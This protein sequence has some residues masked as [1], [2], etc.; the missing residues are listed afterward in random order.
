MAE[1]NN[2]SM[3]NGPCCDIQSRNLILQMMD[4][5]C[6]SSGYEKGRRDYLSSS[7]EK[8]LGE[9]DKKESRDPKEV[10][11]KL[12]E[13]LEKKGKAF[14]HTA[15]YYHAIEDEQER[16]KAYR[17]LTVSST[18]PHG[19]DA[20]IAENPFKFLYLPED[21]TFGQTRVAWLRLSK[22]W[23]PD[24]MYPE[25]PDQYQ[26]IFG[27]SKFPI[28][29]KEYDFWLKEI[30][31]IKLP[32]MLS[33]EELEKLGEREQEEYLQK[34]EA[35]RNK[36]LE[37]EKVKSDMRLRA[38][39]KMQI[40]NK[41]YAE[42]KKRFSDFEQE[43]FAGF[44][45]EMGARTSDYL[46]LFMGV[47]V[48]FEYDGLNLEG[49]GQVRRDMGL[50]AINSLAYLAFDYGE[51]YLG[52]NDYRQRLNLRSFFAWTE[53]VQGKELCPTLLEDVVETYKLNEDQSEQLRLMIM[54][55]EE[56]NFIVSALEIPTDCDDHYEMSQFLEDIYDCPM[57]SH[58]LIGRT[59]FSFP[60][61][62]EFS[63]EGGLKLTYKS[64]IDSFTMSARDRNA[65]F[66][67][68]DVQMMIAI[69]YGPLLQKVNTE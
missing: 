39:Q 1:S 48:S 17:G 10:T 18:V 13:L 37:Y 32:K 45:W 68:T 33:A 46:D 5:D 58:D 60:L 24:L 21:A 69:A 9:E 64:Q 61:G 43:S 29:G 14:L 59:T 36:E 41:A 52:D 40:L 23:F 25:N 34:M 62:V 63:P 66:T 67:Q 27:D 31:S 12:K 44:L 53:L 2:N 55:R 6:D 49:D 26:R 16:M 65:Q 22:S 8:M 50:W 47:R 35:Y 3:I 30:N 4:Y 54:N 28:E 51:I 38:T 20:E 11:D 19:E 57:F 15:E 42:A 7:L 56:Y